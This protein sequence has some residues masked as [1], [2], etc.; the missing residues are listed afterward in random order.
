MCICMCLHKCMY[1]CANSIDM[2]VLRSKVSYLLNSVYLKPIPVEKL[3]DYSW[4]CSLPQLCLNY[5]F[6]SPRMS[7]CTVCVG[8]EL[9]T[10]F[11]LSLQMLQVVS[12][13]SYI[14]TKITNCTCFICK[15]CKQFNYAS[16]CQSL[17]FSSCVVMLIKLHAGSLKP[18]F[19]FHVS[20]GK[21]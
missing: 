11:L 21:S 9:F 14:Q 19:I 16:C 7:I 1:T 8:V 18:W 20:E 13:L 5:C 15:K 3:Q 2:I 4:P 17:L 10:Y 6:S 12:V